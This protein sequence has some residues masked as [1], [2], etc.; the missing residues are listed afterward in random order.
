MTRKPFTIPNAENNPTQKMQI[1]WVPRFVSHGRNALRFASD[2]AFAYTPR[3]FRAILGAATGP[4]SR[5]LYQRIKESF[6]IAAGISP[7][8]PTTPRLHPRWPL[9]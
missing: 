5:P 7:P 6:S 2:R 9:T 1:F 4:Q 3:R 8:C